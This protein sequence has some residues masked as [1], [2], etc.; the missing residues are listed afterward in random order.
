MMYRI[1]LGLL[2]GLFLAT[3]LQAQDAVATK[4]VEQLVVKTTDERIASRMTEGEDPA[5]LKDGEHYVLTM[6]DEG[7]FT[8]TTAVGKVPFLAIDMRPALLMETFAEQVEQARGMAGMAASMG[9][10]NSPVKPEDMTKMVESFFDFPKQIDTVSLVIERDQQKNYDAHAELVP[11]AKTAFATTMAAMRSSG[12]G[13]PQLDNAGGA[14]VMAL[15]VDSAAAKTVVEPFMTWSMGLIG[16]ADP[17]FAKLFAANW[18]QMDG[19]GVFSVGAGQMRM[20]FGSLDPTKLKQLIFSEEWLAL[21]RSMKSGPGFEMK[22]TRDKVGDL[23]VLRSEGTIEGENPIFKD[24]KISGYTA[25]AG[26]YMAVDMNGGQPA[27]EALVA[28]LTAG[29]V[30][31]APLTGSAFMTMQMRLADL[32]AM[33]EGSDI[34]TSRMPQ[35]IDVALGKSGQSTLKVDVRVKM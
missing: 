6:S 5:P 32:L 19:T 3:P 4:S 17:A 28:T 24:G 14:M 23:D 30:K 15:D 2:G 35:L 22:V 27:F 20:L 8:C 18:A 33:N 25:V 29:K 12:K 10:A 7:D 34:D 31:R 1:T 21:Q 13:A 11:I 26:D 9:A 16:Q